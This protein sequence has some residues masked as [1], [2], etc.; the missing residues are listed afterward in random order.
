LIVQAT[1]YMCDAGARHQHQSRS[2]VVVTIYHNPRCSKSRATLAL[3]R[4]RGI[5][6]LVVDYRE[7]PPSEEEFRRILGLLGMRPRQ[8]VRA[9]DAR[10]AGID[11][12]G[13]GDDD[14]IRA[15]LAHPIII[16]RPIVVANDQARLGRP[17]EN[18]LDIL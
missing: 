16:E 6:P 9:A 18:V 3:L 14:L 2:E 13:L 1:R 5:E 10:A 12:G 7:N 4:A 17:P 8:L 11:H 15:M